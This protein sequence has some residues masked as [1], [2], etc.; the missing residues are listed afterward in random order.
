MKAQRTFVQ[1]C[2]APHQEKLQR[3]YYGYLRL[4]AFMLYSRQ[5]E[6]RDLMEV[7]TRTRRFIQPRER[8]GH[9]SV[10]VLAVIVVALL[11]GGRPWP[12]PV[13]AQP[14]VTGVADSTITTCIAVGPDE[15]SPGV[16]EVEQ[17][18]ILNFTGTPTAA[19]L[20]AYAFSVN[21]IANNHIYINGRW[22]GQPK[23]HTSAPKCEI[24]DPAAQRMEWDIDPAILV[25]GVNR[26]KL[27][28]YSVDTKGWGLVRAKIQVTGPDVNGVRYEEFTAPSTYYNNWSDYKNEGT[29]TQIQ[30]PSSYDGSQP[31]PLVMAV[32]GLGSTRLDSILDF[33]AAAEAR[34][35]LL[36]APELHGETN[37]TNRGK[38][39]GHHVFGAPA[40]QWDVMDA[41]R[42][43]KANY[44]VDE[45]RIYLIGHSLGAITAGLVAAKWPQEFAAVV[46]DSGPTDLVKWE[47][48]MRP[49]GATPNAV[50]LN[51]LRKECGLYTA[52]E[53][54][55]IDPQT[56]SENP[57]CYARRSLVQYAPNFKHMPVLIVHGQADTKV[58]P[59]HAQN[60]YN[61]LQRYN[62]DRVDLWWHSGGHG[63]RYPD[64]ANAY[65]DWLAQ[66]TRGEMPT[67]IA[68][69]RDEPGRTYWVNVSQ[70]NLHWTSVWSARYDAAD[71][72]VLATVEDDEGASIGFDLGT[73][74]ASSGITGYIVED[75]A[76]DA[77]SFSAAPAVSVG[78]VVTVTVTPGAHRYRLYPGDTPLPYATVTLQQGK[79]GY[80]GAADTYISAWE[81]DTNYA[82]YQVLRVRHDGPT[83]IRN[84]LLRFNLDGRVPPDIWLRGAVLRLYADRGP[85]QA[86]SLMIDMHAA[87]RPWNAAEATWNRPQVGETWAQPGANGMPGDIA[88]APAD[89]R[90]V[91]STD[92][93]DINRWYGWD[94]TDL[95]ATWLATP[96]ANYGVV[97]RASPPE[98]EYD[99]REEFSFYS[100]EN[101][102]AKR[103]QLMI[104][105]A[106]VT[107]TPTPTPTPT[108]TPT[109]TA[110]PTPATGDV[111]GYTFLDENGDGFRQPEE[112]GIADVPVELRQGSVVIASQTS[113]ADGAFAFTGIMPGSYT[114]VAG[115]PAGYRPT[116]STAIGVNVVGGQVITWDFGYR[117]LS[118]VYLPTL[119]RGP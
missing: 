85:T 42:W 34:G 90:F 21:A 73:I 59:H 15:F 49:D 29:W 12:V 105:Y 103:P 22:V 43:I 56:P 100:S 107:P 62:V 92:T 35:W 32:H 66:F 47:Y 84:T 30:I 51:Y 68:F 74:R 87:G 10:F 70:S 54:Y 13:S 39:V 17:E 36:A 80:T 82:N 75:L 89:T 45:N 83:T 20:I 8:Q 111:Q 119:W 27:V 94:V 18:V 53:H 50:D 101:T 55:V 67:E 16:N 57:Y 23:W 41:L 58:A 11:M 48:E 7:I 110:T 3:F 61:L 113:G 93:G 24:T 104:V 1:R 112:P 79:D 118:R 31:V 114:L 9:L 4:I 88:S 115:V 2:V 64:F 76:K 97:V 69:R 71:D 46:L 52:A 77:G 95:V 44:N 96:E 117:R 81:P 108:V 63:D 102:A 65:L 6:L 109:P 33:A 40:S 78:G 86:R 5:R 60:F 19:K 106:L 26:I 28:N 25:N 99:E 72:T 37:P 14:S 38:P 91:Q 98:D 116:G